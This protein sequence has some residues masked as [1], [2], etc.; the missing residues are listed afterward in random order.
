[1]R[2]ATIDNSQDVMDSR[3]IIARIDELTGER[4]TA[5][6]EAKEEFEAARISAR[7][8]AAA[9]N[10]PAPEET[11]FDEAAWVWDDD[12]SR[13]ELKALEALAEEASGSPDWPHGETLIR[14]SY[15]ETYAQDLADDLGYIKADVHWPYN[16]IDWERAARELQMDYTSVDFDGVDY[17]IR[18]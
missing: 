16:C 18:S 17:W 7:I 15:F 8:E 1:M 10:M 13:D 3:D 12:D 14:A 4:D 6:E 9:D 2:H 11:D 5:L